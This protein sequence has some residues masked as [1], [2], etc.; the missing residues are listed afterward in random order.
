MAKT[1][2][3]RIRCNECGSRSMAFI[4]RNADTHTAFMPWPTVLTRARL[5]FFP[6]ARVCDGEL[7]Y[8]QDM[9][10]C[11]YIVG[12]EC[13]SLRCWEGSYHADVESTPRVRTISKHTMYSIAMSYSFFGFIIGDMYCGTGLT[14]F[15]MSLSALFIFWLHHWWHVLWD[16]ADRV[17]C[18]CPKTPAFQQN[19]LFF[20]W[21]VDTSLK[22]GHF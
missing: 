9:W 6:R 7:F 22:S 8:A 4:I 21:D 11:I 1:T 15:S 12:S 20:F 16:R 18:T 3:L 17:L 5:L 10:V 14:E 2:L 13:Q 19:C